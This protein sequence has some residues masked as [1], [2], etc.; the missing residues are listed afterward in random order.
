[1]VPFPSPRVATNVSGGIG[2]L[3]VLNVARCGPI[4]TTVATLKELLNAVPGAIYQAGSARLN[5]VRL[6]AAMWS[7]VNGR[8]V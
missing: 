7:G 3:S 2:V 4:I 1:M 8:V 6:H 5:I